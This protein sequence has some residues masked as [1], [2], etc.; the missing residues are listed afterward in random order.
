[1]QDSAPQSKP[2]TDDDDELDALE[3]VDGVE[4]DD[5]G[6]LYEH[7]RFVADKGQQL[8]R[9]DKFLVA[10]IEKS[11]RNRIQQAADAGC[12]LVNGKPGEIQL[13]REA[14]RCGER[15]HGPS[16]LRA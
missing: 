4:G 7:F 8:L 15:G 6:G 3:G 10:R 9:V 5:G 13:P 2:M 16:A 12:I 11:S 14:S 1:M